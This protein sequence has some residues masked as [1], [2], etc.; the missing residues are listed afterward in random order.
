MTISRTATSM[1]GVHDW[2]HDAYQDLHSGRHA[3]DGP[4]ANV[5]GQAV[6]RCTHGPQQWSWPAFP[7]P[8][9]H[10][11]RLPQQGQGTISNPHVASS[12]SSRF[13]LVHYRSSR[14]AQGE[15]SGH[16]LLSMLQS[17][18]AMINERPPWQGHGG[19]NSHVLPTATL[20]SW[21]H[22]ILKN[23]RQLRQDSISG[24]ASCSV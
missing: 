15:N 18:P 16:T 14:Q 19:L 21:M 5:L 9:W 22:R 12:A 3:W 10:A 23:R 24:T 17:H 7:Q 13:L 11:E 4:A 8:G 20:R 2:T 1:P 6:I